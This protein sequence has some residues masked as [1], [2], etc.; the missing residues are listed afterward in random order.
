MT[1]QIQLPVNSNNFPKCN[2]QLMIVV[3]MCYLVASTSAIDPSSTTYRG[4]DTSLVL[5]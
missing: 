1:T 2:G 4:K 5:H 3:I